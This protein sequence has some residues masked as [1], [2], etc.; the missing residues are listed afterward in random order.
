MKNLTAVVNIFV[1]DGPDT[2][3]YTLVNTEDL[4]SFHNIWPKADMACAFPTL[5]FQTKLVWII[6]KINLMVST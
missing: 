2:A 1:W 5:V 3:Q 4:L 6:T